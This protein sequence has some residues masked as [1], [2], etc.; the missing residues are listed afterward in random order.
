MALKNQKN[1]STGYENT[2]HRQNTEHPEVYP[3]MADNYG[4]GKTQNKIIKSPPE[5]FAPARGWSAFG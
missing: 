3:P 4:A 5:D 2:K 1:K